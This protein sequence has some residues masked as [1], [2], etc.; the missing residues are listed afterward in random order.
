MLT[1][2]RLFVVL[3]LVQLDDSFVYYATLSR[4][5]ETIDRVIAGELPPYRPAVS[6]LVKNAEGLRDLMKKCWLEHPDVRPSFHELCKE[7]EA[8]KKANGL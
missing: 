2:F 3:N 5:Q 4:F 6:D 1:I 7:I 8:L